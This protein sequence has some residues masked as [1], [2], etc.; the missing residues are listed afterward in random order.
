MEGWRMHLERSRGRHPGPLLC[1]GYTG[2]GREIETAQAMQTW[3]RAVG[4]RLGDLR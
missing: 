3:L 1:L 4:R 2:K